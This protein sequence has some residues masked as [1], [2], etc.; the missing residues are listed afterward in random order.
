[1]MKTFDNLTVKKDGDCFLDGK[2]VYA[3]IG[4][5]CIWIPDLELKFVWSFNGRAISFYDWKKG[6]EAKALCDFTFNDENRGFCK[7][8]IDSIKSEVA[9]FKLLS[10]LKMSPPVSNLVYANTVT[11]DF[12]GP[13]H[14]DPKGIYGYHMKDARK[15]EPGKFDFSKLKRNFIDTGILKGSKGAFGDITKSNNIIN[16]YLIDLRRTLWDMVKTQTNNLCDIDSFSHIPS[17]E[18]LVDCIHTEGQFPFKKRKEGYQTC[19]LNGEWEAG[20]R[21]TEYRLD[22]MEVPLRTFKASVLDLGCQTGS[23]SNQMWLRGARKITGIDNQKEFIDLAQKIAKFNGTQINY[24]VGDLSKPALVAQYVNSYYP[25]KIDFV[26]ALSL[27]KHIGL[28]LFDILNEISWHTCYLES[29]NAP[30][31]LNTA[32]VKEMEDAIRNIKC[33]VDFLGMTEDRSPRCIWRLVR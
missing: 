28:S 12:L 16:G 5:H 2:K 11:S 9:L 13:L 10:N 20:S 30:K 8:T 19:W 33:Q 22:K 25:G 27:Y 18:V 24:V 29:N 4:K 21:D 26:F 17:K 3:I 23:I 31:G 1:M 7:E 15:L 6:K 14:C 32:H